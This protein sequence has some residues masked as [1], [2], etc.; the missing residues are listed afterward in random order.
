MSRNV[1][2]S[3]IIQ[4]VALTTTTL[5]RLAQAQNSPNTE[6]DQGTPTREEFNA[7]KEELRQTKAELADVKKQAANAPSSTDMDD[8]DRRLKEASDA[9]SRALPG[10]ETVVL[11]GDA[12]IGFTVP[13][14][15]HST[16]EAGIAPLILYRPADHLLF[17]AAADIGVSTDDA[18]N[19]STSFDLTIAN[20]SYEVTDWLVL[21]GGLFVVPFGV[22]HNHFDPPWINKFP[23]D[24]LVFGD[25]AI[26][27]SSEVGIFARGAV[28]ISSTKLTYDLYLTNGPQLI[29][30]DPAAA[31]SLNFDD[32]T[33]LNNNKAVGGR[34]GFLPVPNVEVGY[35]IQYSMPGAPP[36]D[37]VSALLQAV[38]LNWRQEVPALVGTFDVRGEWVYS[39][40]SSATYDPSGAL[41]IGPVTFGNYRNGGYAQLCYRP[42]LVTNKIIRN[43]ELCTRYDRV[44]SP[45]NS[46]GGEREQ[47]WIF[48][49][50]YWLA[51]N[52]VIKV[53][54]ELDNKTVGEDQN[55]LL[56]QFGIGL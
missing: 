47:R 4:I 33:D 7:V 10:K 44:E 25:A 17:E 34:I 14:H 49:V 5:V 8:F 41:G 54:Y 15:G 3:L 50:D 55:A 2:L 21:G 28:P 51:P 52:A 26:A 24:P 31:G 36:F 38:D 9:I 35:S 48:G 29:T 39:A 32:F 16:F 12:A 30:T 53:A 43:I 27:P 22:Y 20:A 19:S 45:L 37:H 6:V 1:R 56:V 40:V 11:A 42:T 46:P 18:G 23:D 13:R